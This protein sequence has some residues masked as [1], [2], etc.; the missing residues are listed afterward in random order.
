MNENVG[1]LARR[2]VGLAVRRPGL[3]VGLWGEAGIGKTH[4]TQALLSETP[5][6]SVSVRSTQAMDVVVGVIPT[7]KRPSVWLERAAERVRQGQPLK[8]EA[9][10]QTLAGLLSANAPLIVHVEDLHEA[11]PEQLEVWT[12]L[13][14]A[15]TRTRGVGLIATSRVSPPNG[16]EA[17][18]LEPLDRFASDAALEV[19]AG[20]ILPVEACAWIF[21][22]ARGN[23]LFT[24]EFFRFLSRHGFVWND[25]RRWRWRAPVRSVIPITVEATIERVIAEAGSNIETRMALKARAYLDSLEPNLKL[26]PE[27]WA[28]VA[29]LQSEALERAERN[30]R[31][32]G[33]LNESGFVHPLFREVPVNGLNA[34]DRKLF[35]NQALEVLP[36]GIAAVFI[37]DAQL[38]PERS[39][40]LLKRAAEASNAPGRWLALAVEYSSGLDRSRLALE[41][42]RELTATDLHQAQKQFRLALEG[43]SDPAITLEFIVFLSPHQPVEAKALFEALPKDLRTSAQGLVARFQMMVAGSD[44]SGIIDCWRNEF[45]SSS[46]LSPDALVHVIQSLTLSDRCEEAI[47]LADGVLARSDLSP[48]QRARVMNRKYNAHGQANRSVQA[49]E[50]TN[51]VLKW[52]ASHGLPGRDMILHDRAMYRTHLGDYRVARTDY[53]EALQLA[54]AIGRTSNEM[55]IYLA[56]GQLHGE[57]GEFALA[58]EFL[59]EAFD[60]LVCHPIGE[61]LCD[62]TNALIEL[63]VAW[64]DRPSS[65][66]LAHKYVRLSLEYADA[67]GFPA[68]LA[69]SRT[70]AGFAELEYG[71]PSRAL[72]LALEALGFR[73]MDHQFYGRWF[74]TWLEAKARSKLGEQARALGLLEQSI[75][76]FGQIGRVVQVNLAGLDLDRL[77]NDPESAR[78]RLDWFRERGLTNAVQA[79]LRL[80]PEL[81]SA[82]IKA[83]PQARTGVQLQVLGSV[84]MLIA[85]KPEPVRGGKRKELLALLLEARIQG[86]SEVSRLNLFDALYSDDSEAQ[87]GAALSSLV[88]QLREQFGP[89]TVLSSDGGYALGGVTSDAEA[90]LEAG[91]TRLWRGDYLEGLNLERSDTVR[92]TLHLALRRRADSLLETDPTEAARVGRLLCEAD[93]YELESLRLTLRALRASANHKSL[94][95]TYARARAG[96]LEIGEVLPERWA[97]FLEMPIGKTV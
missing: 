71:S 87:A 59:L 50:L 68:Y 40:E 89:N 76:G 75:A 65:G 14:L 11:G 29:G 33:V 80:F 23:P 92:E 32:R 73:A 96:L 39:L 51:H 93:P 69:A 13:A 26:K 86:R 44:V 22:H 74:P 6:N 81:A 27:V 31:A 62:T 56:L 24:L 15:V 94:K 7:P 20:G 8:V 57:F 64:R 21:E 16:F 25:S 38:G 2:L 78:D 77:R 41:A 4:L 45:G 91:D 97:D 82:A 95:G 79:G 19:E 54:R 85:G 55:G 36:I 49:L 67:T 60:Y 63:Y 84:Q 5:I 17:F 52:L 43:N 37:A 66:L 30:L 83:S 53:E 61:N 28:H 72:E 46:D 70:F 90:F 88:Y 1:R 34:R 10:V 3:A 47:S 48:W 12:Q 58:E 18:K 9:L 35:A 42:A